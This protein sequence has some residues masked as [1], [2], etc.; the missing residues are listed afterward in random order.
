M[1][2]K[3]FF[4]DFHTGTSTNLLKKFQKMCIAAGIN[5]ID[6]DKKF[7]AIKIH[8]GEPG[9]LAYIR[10][11]YVKALVE[12]IEKKGGIPFLTDCNTLYAG[13]RKHAVEH[14]DT[15]FENGFSP[16]S[17]GCHVI[18]G[19]G[20]KGTDQT[21]IP[22]PNGELVKTAKIG[23]AIADADIIISLNHFKCHESAGIGGALKNLGMGC[24]SRAGKMEQ[25]CEGKLAVN[26]KLC[27]LC[28]QCAKQCAQGAIGYDTGVALIDKNKCVGCGRCLGYCNF[29]A[30]YNGNYDANDNFTK[31]MVEYAAA[32]IAN[33][34][35]FHINL[36]MDISPLCDCRGYNDT[37]IVSD[38]GMFA[39]LD[40]V[41]IDVACVD[42][43]NNSAPMPNSEL[44]K[45][46]S[47]CKCG[48]EHTD[49]FNI[50]NKSSDYRVSIDYAVK[51]GL[52]D[53]KYDLV[54]LK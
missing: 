45:A 17:T 18:I 3:V 24:A 10:P 9:N 41:A 21:E 30:I 6:M 1:S 32:V 48:K 47:G 53:D 40:P 5:D 26:P 8:F 33:K 25:H 15:A 39:S 13:R 16:F 44:S 23:K 36:A 7:V 20:L 11:N 38:I 27:R 35:S 52:G 43:V 50:V 42:A 49:Y 2:S 12:L 28:R 34:P 51:I 22:V 19:D 14:L 37:P 31:K 29:N 54:T 4:T 46:L